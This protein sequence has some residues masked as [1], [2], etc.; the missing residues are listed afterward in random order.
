MFRSAT[1]QHPLGKFLRHLVEVPDAEVIVVDGGSSDG[2]PELAAGFCDQLLRTRWGRAKQMNAGAAVAHGEVFWFL[3]VVSQLLRDA[4]EAIARCLANPEIAGGCFRLEMPRR[5]LIYRVTDMLGSLAEDPEL[6]RNLGEIGGVKQL[7]PA[8]RRS[9][10][11]FERVGRYRTTAT[12]AAILA[13]YLVGVA[14]PL[15]HKAYLRLHRRSQ[16]NIAST[17]KMPDSFSRPAFRCQQS[18]KN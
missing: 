3:H 13:L 7:K 18:N 10:R 16:M 12:Y 8:T 4:L 1:K 6:Y 17:A 2:T 15:L 14:T 11:A 9:P 5:E